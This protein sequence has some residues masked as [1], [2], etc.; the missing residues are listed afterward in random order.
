M[1]TVWQLEMFCEVMTMQQAGY[2]MLMDYLQ[3]N[4]REQQQQFMGQV[5]SS[6]TGTEE[7]LTPVCSSEPENI[8][9]APYNLS[10]L[11]VTWER[12]RAVYDASI[13]KYSVSYGLVNAENSAP[14][15]YLTDGDQDVGAILDDLSANTSYVVQVVAV[16]TNGLYG[17]VS[18]QLTVVM[19][20]DDPE[21]ALDPDSDE[22]DDESVYEPDTSE[23]AQTEDYDLILSLTQSPTTT[24]TGSPPLPAPDITTTAA[25]GGQRRTSTDLVPPPRSTQSVQVLS[26][27]EETSRSTTVQPPEVTLSPDSSGETDFK[28]PFDS[29]ATATT[30]TKEFISTSSSPS[31]SSTETEGVLGGISPKG[32]GRTTAAASTTT[33]TDGAE[34]A[35]G[36]EGASSHSSTTTT[37][38]S[39]TSDTSGTTASPSVIQTETVRVLG[40]PINEEDTDPEGGGPPEIQTS[41]PNLPHRAKLLHVVLRLPACLVFRLQRPLCG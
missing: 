38:T 26:N 11:L 18:D 16:C 25:E 39:R 41:T 36:A 15:E 34:G 9:A 14:S 35:E 2:V 5:F 31:H 21:N 6:Y 33:K 23:P 28:A 3:N 13:E 32:G 7:V 40:R 24:T 27:S 12:P 37:V 19:P 20:V 17:R 29:T 22:F 1:V 8:Q 4:Y 10:S 30:T